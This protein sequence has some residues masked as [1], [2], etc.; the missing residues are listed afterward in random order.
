MYQ[1][2]GIYIKESTTKIKV[3]N[4]FMSIFFDFM[5]VFLCILVTVL[6]GS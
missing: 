3:V 1:T 2:S 5:E 4:V 6:Y